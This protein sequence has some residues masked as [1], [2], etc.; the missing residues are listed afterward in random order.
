MSR[1]VPGLLLKPVLL[2]G[3]QVMLPFASDKPVQ[4]PKLLLEGGHLHPR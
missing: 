2:A 1:F 4:E 3:R